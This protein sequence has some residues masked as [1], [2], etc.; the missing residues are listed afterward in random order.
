MNKNYLT[1][2]EFIRDIQLKGGT[3][4]QAVEMWNAADEIADSFERDGIN[5]VADLSEG[6]IRDA[7]ADWRAIK[8]LGL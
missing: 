8:E 2:L 6:D 1:R 7:V 5:V 4:A 3:Y